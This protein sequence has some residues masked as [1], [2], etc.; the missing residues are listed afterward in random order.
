MEILMRLCAHWVCVTYTLENNTKTTDLSF[1]AFAELGKHRSVNRV[2]HSTFA[3][4]A[5]WT[6]VALTQNFWDVKRTPNFF[7]QRVT[8]SW[9]IRVRIGFC[10]H[11]SLIGSWLCQPNFGS[12]SHLPWPPWISRPSTTYGCHGIK[13]RNDLPRNPSVGNL[14]EAEIFTQFKYSSATQHADPL[15]VSF[16]QNKETTTQCFKS[17]SSKQGGHMDQIKKNRHENPRRCHWGNSSPSSSPCT[18]HP[19]FWATTDYKLPP[20]AALTMP[21]TSQRCPT[22]SIGKQQPVE[23]LYKGRIF[24][25]RK[26]THQPRKALAKSSGDTTTQHV[27]TGNRRYPEKICVSWVVRSRPVSWLLVAQWWLPTP[28][29]TDANMITSIMLNMR[30]ARV[31]VDLPFY[32]LGGPSLVVSFFFWFVD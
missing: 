4:R 7:H 26:E 8:I 28:A 2:L 1:A 32:P 21:R 9:G 25:E 3:M 17:V 27:F 19:A 29:I 16:S 6:V 22:G 18:V 10:H 20:N 15:S 31:L 11:F 12:T 23:R 13:T 24:L 14:T 30:P 5:S